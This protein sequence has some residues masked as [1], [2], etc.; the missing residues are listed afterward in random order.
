MQSLHQATHLQ[1]HHRSLLH[2]YH[3]APPIQLPVLTVMLTSMMI[4]WPILS[5]SIINN[6]IYI[7]IEIPYRSFLRR[8][9]RALFFRHWRNKS[10]VKRTDL[11]L[12]Q[13]LFH[14]ATVRFPA[15]LVKQEKLYP[16][17]LQYP[18]L[19]LFLHFGGI[20]EW[21]MGM[22]KDRF[23]DGFVSIFVMAVNHD[24]LS[25]YLFLMGNLSV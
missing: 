16:I 3:V 5:T 4:N 19:H 17:W 12:E 6:S 7:D 15:L 21:E 2:Q 8:P 25:L 9:L 14:S 18:I 24:E 23:A 1:H 20:V 13:S 22:W 10:C 11:D